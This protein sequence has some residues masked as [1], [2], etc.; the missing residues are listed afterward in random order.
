MSS[1]FQMIYSVATSRPAFPLGATN[2]FFVDV[3][4]GQ[5]YTQVKY[6]GGGTLEILQCSSGASLASGGSQLY[7]TPNFI[8][9]STLP[10]TMLIAM[11]GTGYMMSAN[12]VVTLAGPCRFYLLQTG[13]TGLICLM[14]GLG[15]GV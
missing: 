12:E 1:P 10:G 3:Q 14:K 9:G 8:S 6:F 5:L 7:G 15:A 4:P 13:T 2:A 11:A